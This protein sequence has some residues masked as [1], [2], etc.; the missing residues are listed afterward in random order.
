M[1]ST[2]QIKRFLW[3]FPLLVV[4]SVG[5]IS[6][7]SCVPNAECS[8]TNVSFSKCVQPILVSNCSGSG[9][10]GAEG[11][12]LIQLEKDTH[13]SIVGGTDGVSSG[14]NFPM[15]QIAPGDPDN[16]YLYLKISQEKPKVG[17]RMPLD[18]APLYA[19]QLEAIRTWIAEGAKNN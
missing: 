7:P 2:R 19:N 14:Q 5:L 6:L 13:Q 4:A 10:H 15:K 17:A 8:D 12:Q 3:L 18:R 1:S 11:F 16:S 9:C